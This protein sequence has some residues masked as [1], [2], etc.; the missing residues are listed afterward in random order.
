MTISAHLKTNRFEALYDKGDQYFEIFSLD[1]Y[2]AVLMTFNDIEQL[3]TW[4]ALAHE[5]AMND[6][7]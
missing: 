5:G 2:E 7:E 1:S 3:Y 6:S 4:A